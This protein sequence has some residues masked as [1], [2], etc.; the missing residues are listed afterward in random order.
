VGCNTKEPSNIDP[1]PVED[2]NANADGDCMTD[3]EEIALGTDPKKIDTDAD[4]ISDCDEVDL[5]TDP[6]KADSDGDT[7]NDPDE[8]ACVSSPTAA[9]EKCYAC[10]WKHNDPGNLAATGKNPGDVIGNMEIVDQ[11]LETI[12]L[13][14]FAAT[15][16]SPVPQPAEY[17]ILFMT[18]AW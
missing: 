14:D 6:V 10:G 1:G 4:T 15:P 2:P 7:I 16:D 8:V 11:C 3:K 17:H 13:W 5:G 9:A 18:A 12:S